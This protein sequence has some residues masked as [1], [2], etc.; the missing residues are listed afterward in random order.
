MAHASLTEAVQVTGHPA[1][2][3]TNKT[4]TVVTFRK[5]VQDCVCYDVGFSTALV[6]SG[7]GQQ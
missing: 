4:L 5:Q 3:L 2:K 7:Q 1:N 6:R